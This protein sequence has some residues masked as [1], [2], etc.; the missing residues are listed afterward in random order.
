MRF[1]M[2]N[3]DLSAEEGAKVHACAIERSI[4]RIVVESVN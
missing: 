4:K 3:D 1:S 2:K